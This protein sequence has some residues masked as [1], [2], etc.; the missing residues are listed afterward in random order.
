MQISASG[1]SHLPPIEDEIGSL[2]DRATQ[3]L[4]A[5]PSES[6]VASLLA[7]GLDAVL[8]GPQS[9]YAGAKASV[10]RKIQQAE[11]WKGVLTDLLRQI[12]LLDARRARLERFG[13]RWWQ[14]KRAA[15]HNEFQA[16]AARGA[17]MW[18][19]TYVEALIAGEG[20]I[21]RALVDEPLPWSDGHTQD[22][23]LFRAGTRA[24]IDKRY[25]DVLPLLDDLVRD[26]TANPRLPQLDSSSRAL[27]LIFAGRIH[28][29]DRDDKAQ[30]LDCFSRAE[31]CGVPDGRIHAALGEYDRKIG[32]AEDALG[33]FQDAITT[34]PE[35]P[36]GYVGL[37][38]HF[39]AEKR[40]EEAD[41]WFD[42]AVQRVRDEKAPLAAL[43]NLRAP[44]S[45]R[46]CLQ[47]A[48]AV[49]AANPQAAL[50][51]VERALSLGVEGPGDY[52]EFAAYE[53]KGE[54]L[55][56]LDPDHPADAAEA[57]YQAGLRR[58]WRNEAADATALFKR[59]LTLDRQHLPTYWRLADGLLTQSYADKT[60]YVNEGPLAEAA[61]F[62][63]EG[64]RH[65]QPSDEDGW[66]YLTRALINEQYARL[67]GQ[68][69]WTLLWQAIAWTEQ[70]LLKLPQH[71]IAWA[72]LSRLHRALGNDANALRASELAPDNV[73]ALEERI[74]LLANLFRLDEAR[75]AIQRRR[76]LTKADEAWSDAALAHMDLYGPQKE[77]D[78]A[79]LEFWLAAFDTALKTS[80]DSPPWS[81][82]RARVLWRLG[83]TEEARQV[84]ATL[85]RTFN[86]KSAED[87]TTYAWAGLISGDVGGATAILEG[88]LAE[89]VKDASALHR[90][91]GLCYLTSNRFDEAQRHLKLGIEQAHSAPELAGWLVSEVG[92][93]QSDLVSPLL[94]AE[95]REVLD[96]AIAQA[97]QQK[98]KISEPATPFE[99]IKRVLD[100][101]AP[102]NERD[103][104]AWVG[105]RMTEARLHGEAARWSEAAEVYAALRPYAELVPEVERGAIRAIE[106]LQSLADAELRAGRSDSALHSYQSL[107][108]RLSETSS[109]ANDERLAGLNVRAG[110][111]HLYRQDTSEA[112]GHFAKALAL[113]AHGTPSGPAPAWVSSAGSGAGARLASECAPLA[114]EAHRW[115]TVDDAWQAW[116]E[117][118]A[119]DDALRTELVAARSLW[120]DHLARRF[121]LSAD[122]ARSKNFYT[123]VSPL[124]LELGRGLAEQSYEESAL[125][126]DYL[127]TVIEGFRRDY[128][129]RIPMPRV[130]DSSDVDE[131]AEAY[132]VMLD[133]VPIVLGR[134]H[135]GERFAPR[136]RKET[137]V[138]KD[139][140]AN[141]LEEADGPGGDTGCWVAR[142][143]WKAVE[144][145][146]E[147]LW[148]DETVFAAFHLRAILRGNLAD[149]LGVQDMEALIESWREETPGADPSV[150]SLPADQARLRFAR[151]LR[152]LVR[153]RVPIIAWQ[154]ILATVR[155]T[156]LAK[157]DLTDMVR[158]VRLRLKAQ[159]P[160]AD[161]YTARI[162]LTEDLEARIDPW[163]RHQDGKHFFAIPPED[164]QELLADIRELVRDAPHRP[165]LVTS[166][167]DLRPFIRRLV[168]LE[169]PDLMVLADE[170]LSATD[171]ALNAEDAGATA[172][173]EP[174]G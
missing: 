23:N 131:L 124:A 46:L 118:A 129:V 150:V 14:D 138:A 9:D 113:Y 38:L 18:L 20:E 165:V 15:L 22:L 160:G 72:S 115:W 107:L 135:V 132:L 98:G 92:D 37:G 171:T 169:F 27:L 100:R 167:G 174:G 49:Q 47:L 119:T 149:L 30:A 25:V 126:K 50:N 163:V 157:D 172:P 122:A 5:V 81:F 82:D 24:L 12:E 143:S 155:E 79:R 89:R 84:L 76:E 106:G 148:P 11:R 170:E 96:Q 141:D 158:A 77:V 140:P 78:A 153:E 16:D 128:G 90:T 26:G 41:A 133:E 2:L 28:L 93:L 152:A 74:I 85:W 88:T 87:R 29:Y 66:A 40:W 136:V 59:A 130:R 137:L 44:T 10:Q 120:L 35:L 109:A 39:A 3:T 60:P 48:R 108:A 80:P 162:R 97:N 34:S 62:W 8:R 86:A 94:S 58:S 43:L 110:M 71:V 56:K 61:E 105:A 142:T 125:K 55:T 166:R 54:L 63:Q 127:P 70:S 45:G 121:Q 147:T 1:D 65:G 21:C 91:L 116:A 42:K 99:E 57:F 103:R 111:A 7:A 83:R 64:M 68:D 117:D 6:V 36:D 101:L 112:R 17:A 173:A 52:P 69:R 144:R 73:Y 95:Q 151:L 139:I 168:E 114:T 31:Q 13:S 53:L 51:A 145:I 161:P 146:G 102:Q 32:R 154:A 75:D 33:R 164:T 4:R 123:M 19:N 104:A 156:G 159:L 67:A 134:V